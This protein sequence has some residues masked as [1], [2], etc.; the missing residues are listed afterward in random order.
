MLKNLF[1]AA[2]KIYTYVIYNMLF[3]IYIRQNTENYVGI[4]MTG[5][6]AL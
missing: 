6:N 4:Q 1:A 2:K 5:F 3:Y